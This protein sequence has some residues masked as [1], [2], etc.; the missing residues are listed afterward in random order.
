MPHQEEQAD[1][2]PVGVGQVLHAK[3]E[4]VKKLGSG[5]YSTV[6]LARD[7]E[8]LSYKAIKILSPECY[9]GK[10]DLFE[11]DILKHLSKANPNHP[12]YQHIPILLGDFV[13]ESQQG[14]HVCLV[15]ELMADDMKGFA[16][17]FEG[18]K[19]PNNIMKRITK[20]LLLAL[21]YA[22]DSGVIHTDIKQD[23]IMVKVRDPS[24]VDRY[25]KDSQS[26]KNI[27][28][29]EYNFDDP[30]EFLEVSIALC[31]W[32][33]ASWEEKHLTPLIQPLLLRAPEVIL[34]APWSKEVDIWNLGALLPELLDAVRMFN[35]RADVTGGD[36]YTKHHIEEID[37]LFGPF[38]PEM[39]K[40][41]DQGI[42][43]QLF[44]ENAQIRDPI[45][46]PPAKL[47]RW[48]ECLD[49][50]EKENFLSM[51]QS[52]LTID[53]KRRITAQAL[54]GALWLT[55]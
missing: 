23:N 51:L 41:G 45:E 3:Y 14:R 37:A 6:W 42:V 29:G 39:L 40:A 31:D 47:E 53:P 22:H 26:I 52:M 10:H 34:Q 11:L 2:E 35:G 8:E 4:V 49:G 5:R 15:M 54:Q 44:D 38:P 19:I 18:V 48:I 46:R 32:G 24:M 36:Y 50:F 16:F 12:G 27:F 1:A 9:D 33:S 21:E 17:F 25:L 43:Q 13:Y 30:S 55:T 20:Q 7:Q 28:L